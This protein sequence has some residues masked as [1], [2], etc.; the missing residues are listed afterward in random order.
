MQPFRVFATK[1]VKRP[2]RPAVGRPTKSNSHELAVFPIG[3][4]V[5]KEVLFNRL[6]VSELGLAYIH[7]SHDFDDEFCLQVTAEKAV[8]KIFEGH[9]QNRVGQ[10]QGK[11]RRLGFKCSELR[12]LYDAKRERDRVVQKL[13]KVQKEK[14]GKIQRRRN[15]FNKW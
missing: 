1:G 13:S 12:I 8:K 10:D 6:K 2:G 3:T 11:E 5:M 4:N 7:I 15:L 9:S 14:P